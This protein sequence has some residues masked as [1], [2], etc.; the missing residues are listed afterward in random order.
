MR[1]ELV[2]KF[3]DSLQTLEKNLP[4]EKFIPSAFLIS[5]LCMFMLSLITYTNIRKY[6]EDINSV[7]RANEVIKQ[8]DRINILSVEIP[9]IRRGYE[10]TGEDKYLKIIDSIKAE[11][12]K[13]INNLKKLTSYEGRDQHKISSL[14][15]IAKVNAELVYSSLNT[16]STSID[17][18]QIEIT[19]IIQNNLNEI[20]RTSDEIVNEELSLLKAKTGNVTSANFTLQI[21]IIITGLFSFLMIGLSLYISSKLIRNKNKAELLLIKSYEDL[22]DIV[23]ERTGELQNSNEK[24]TEEIS[25]REKI[26]NTLRES[27]HRFKM[28][29]DSAPVLIWMTGKDKLSTYVNKGWLEFTGKSLE[30]E[31]GEGWTAD[32][33][34]DD[35][36]KC[37]QT[38]NEAFEK[39]EPFEIELRLKNINGEYVWYLTRGVP[40]YEGNEFVGYIGSCIDINSRKINE[41]YLKV[42]YE[43]SKTLSESKTIEEMSQRV[44]KE[45]CSGIKWNFGQLWTIN[46]DKLSLNSTW[47]DNE[48]DISQYNHIEEKSKTLS[49]AAG[50]PGCVF[51]EK[52]SIWMNDIM[53]DKTFVRKELASRMGWNS[54]LGIPI[55]NG[56]KVIGVIECFNKKSLEERKDLIEVLESAG[57]QIG[58]FI[59]RKRAEEKLKEFYTELEQKI[60][61]RTTELATTLSKLISEMEEKEIIQNKIKILAHAIRSIKDCVFITDLDYNILFVNQAFEDSYG[62]SEEEIHGKKIPLL[63]E[64]AIT[65]NLRDD[66]IKKSLREGWKGELLTLRKDGSKFHTYLSTS[67]IKNEEG[68]TEAIVGISQDISEMKEYEKLISK[69]NNLLNTLNDIIR[70]T[71][72]TFNFESAIQYSINKVCQNTNWEAGHCYLLKNDELTS[73]QIWNEKLPENYSQFKKVSEEAVFI[74]GEGM[75]WNILRSG[76]SEW[77]MIDDLKDEKIYK[78]LNI[79][80]DTGI[81]TGI[82]VPIPMQDENIGVLE[83][84]TR[85]EESKDIEVLECIKNTGIELGSLCEKLNTIKRIN[86]SEKLLNDAQHIAKLG[87]WEWDILKD[88]IQWSDELYSIFEIK[89]QDFA[90]PTYEGYLQ[91]IY[92][93]DREMVNASVKKAMKDKTKFDFFHRILTLSGKIKNVKSQGEI[94]VDDSGTVIRMFGTAHDVTEIKRVE[95]ELLRANAKLVATQ[96]ELIHN[97]KLAALGR[98]SSGVAHEIRN[99]LA[100]IAS[101]AQMVLKADV[102]ERNKKRLRYI[103]TNSEIANDIIKSLLNFASPG[104]LSFTNVDIGRILNNII[105]SVDARR[106]ENKIVIVK[107]IPLSL[108][109]LRVDKLKLENAIMNFVSNAID[110]MPDGGTLTIRVIEDK[111]NK[112]LKMDII[113]TGVGIPTDNMDKIL[114]PFFTTKDEGVG[115]GMGLAY[116]TIRQHSG[117]F[118][119]Q[120][121]EE[122]GTHIEIKLPIENHKTN[123]GKNINR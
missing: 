11:S 119:I 120:S 8:V 97:E 107:E 53:N 49:L 102:D 10:V 9:L 51:K 5:I 66:I 56:D 14:D 108:P 39:K 60:K 89:K 81:K 78:R 36:Q 106:N 113:D 43:V 59:E 95:E 58:N 111:V 77:K 82:W 83:F 52:K 110:A 64:E 50:M 25:E 71:N 17:T 92:D 46:D 72:K 80:K 79:L 68:K 88:T 20:K 37:L 75:P 93:E 2:K 33:Q 90:S 114:E 96:K 40:R 12:V 116:Q 4:L 100:N 115:L 41:T 76:G 30:E 118:R 74:N 16:N 27:E 44:L 62:F 104:D 117:T 65:K 24:L 73:L 48:T 121:I 31:L 18:I 67:S 123:N 35:L 42:Q 101:L 69:R 87:S 26:E 13:Q 6:G 32:V 105:E 54:G 112:I 21:F 1:P 122:H 109:P 47:G 3:S 99:P 86:E 38:Y 22:E 91:R 23:E 61:G 85:E 55:S 94:F 57:R 34:S 28:L 19:K 15:S 45:V 98:F 84:F 63:K 103:L 70:Y 29:A 7:N